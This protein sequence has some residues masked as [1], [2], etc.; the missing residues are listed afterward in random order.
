MYNARVTPNHA[1]KPRN[2]VLFCIIVAT[3]TLINSCGTVPTESGSSVTSPAGAGN[4][5]RS[6]FLAMTFAGDIMAHT[7]NYQMSDYSRIYKGVSRILRS[8]DLTF[9]NLE[10]PVNDSLPLSTYPCFNVH[11]PYVKA[12]VD[13]GFDVLSLANNHSNDK[14]KAGIKGTIDSMARL[15]L[16]GSSCGLRATPDDPMKPLVIRKKGWTI[17]FLAVT[18]ILNSYDQAGKL[19]YYVA[20][21]ETARQAFLEEISAMR[22]QY[23]PDAFVLAIHLNEPEYVRAVSKGKREWFRSLAG[24][25]V[26]VVWGSH[27]HVMQEWEAADVDRGGQTTR[28]LFMYSMGNFISGQRFKLNYE[29]PGALREYTGDAVLLSVKLTRDGASGKNE[30]A[31]SNLPV[32]NYTDPSCGAVVRVF[33]ETFVSS[34]PRKQAKYYRERYRLMRAYLPI[35]PLEP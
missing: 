20:P 10:I 9:G 29:E 6:E 19:V 25:G 11:T 7:V 31:V 18:E 27:P 23:K 14:G 2:A 1:V 21:T 33:N 12:A 13:G 8:D 26:D 4:P 17:L 34:L 22:S 15:G 30:Y 32:T 5:E 28:A 16:S 24:A 3:I 35:L